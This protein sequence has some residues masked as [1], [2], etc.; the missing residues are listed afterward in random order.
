MRADFT[1]TLSSSGPGRNSV[2]LRTKKTY[3]NHLA[4]FDI[5]H[6]PQGCGTWPAVWEVR[7]D[8][9][10]VYGEVDII[11]GVNGQGANLASPHTTSGCMMPSGLKMTG[12][13]PSWLDV[14]GLCDERGVQD[15]DTAE[16]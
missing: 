14:S 4:V 2:R 15:A 11:K 12:Y 9:W 7:E 13:V 1:T 16:L 8:G 10:S 6:M 3:T 5:R